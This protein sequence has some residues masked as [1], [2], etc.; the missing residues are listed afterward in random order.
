M[1]TKGELLA[2]VNAALADTSGVYVNA[3]VD[4]AGYFETLRKSI[5]RHRCAPFPLS[6]TVMSPGFPD[7][8]VGTKITGY[9]VAKDEKAGHWLVYDPERE[10]F[11]C[12]WGKNEKSLGA[13]GVLGS[14]LYCWSA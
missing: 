1:L 9:C 10:T 8:E 2:K 5:E 12:F 4:P 7:I 14:A 6:A 3:G 13:H 11:Y